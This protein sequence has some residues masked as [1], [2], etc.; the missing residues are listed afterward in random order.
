MT[1]NNLSFT[2]STA[3][4]HTQGVRMLNRIVACSQQTLPVSVRQNP[5][6]YQNVKVSKTF[7]SFFDGLSRISGKFIPNSFIYG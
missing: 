7:C 3:L 5:S 1:F 4:K 2:R 6:L